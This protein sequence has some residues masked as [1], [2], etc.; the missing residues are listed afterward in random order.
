MNKHQ[1]LNGLL[2]EL[3]NLPENEKQKSL[4]YYSE[5]ID[6][7]IEDGMSEE[8][9]VSAVGSPEEAAKA[10]LLNQS[11][12]TL[13]KTKV[14]KSHKLRGWE[15]AMLII[16]SPLWIPILLS[17]GIIIFSVFIVMW[18]VIISFYAV[19]VSL[20]ICFP[21]LIVAA[22]IMLL[23]GELPAAMITFGASFISG[24]LSVLSFVGINR[25]AKLLVKLNWIILKGIKFLF[26]TK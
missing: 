6:D 3:S 17:V 20:G 13:I 23:R 21:V 5:M 24:G 2:I 1:F 22:A 8:E 18:S 16:G 25:L 12:H 4:E 26:V 19:S 7:R 9:A 14:K 10:V 11:L 15:I